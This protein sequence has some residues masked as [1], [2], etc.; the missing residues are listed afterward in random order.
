MIKGL[1]CSGPLRRIAPREVGERRLFGPVYHGTSEES[2]KDILGDMGFCFE[3][4]RPREG[5]TVH[6]Y[7]PGEMVEYQG[8]RIPIPTH[9]LGFG[10]YLTTVKSQA[11][12]YTNRTTA[13]NRAMGGSGK[14]KVIEV[15]LD[16]QEY[17]IINFAAMHKMVSWWVGNGYDPSLAKV[18]RTTATIALT[19]SLSSKYEA[20]Y[21]T[22][23]SYR[24]KTNLDGNQICL[25]A[26]MEGKICLIDKS[27]V[28]PGD[29]GSKVRRLS[30]GM[31]GELRKIRSTA[32]SDRFHGYKIGHSRSEAVEIKKECIASGRGWDETADR[33]M[34]K[35]VQF[36]EQYGPD[37]YGAYLEVKWRK[38]GIDLNVYPNEIEFVDR[39]GEL[40]LK[41]MGLV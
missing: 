20:V 11:K 29:V 35:S 14:P 17:E 34:E 38:G 39:P 41:V 13:V 3:R 37:V 2:A 22:A 31:I 21:F 27:L 4:G 40:A 19:V 36:Y 28:V 7:G 18:D 23:A 33:Y 9:F 26:P 30:D 8:E 15:Y 24:G 12:A 16:I 10:V 6:G 32:P 25:Y 5:F 1:E